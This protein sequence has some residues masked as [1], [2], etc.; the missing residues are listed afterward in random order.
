[1]QNYL[2]ADLSGFGYREIGLAAELL[3]ALSNAEYAPGLE[4]IIGAPGLTLEMN[5][6][7]GEVFLVDDDANVYML[8]DS[9][10]LERF[11]NCPECGHESFASEASEVS[12]D[13]VTV[14]VNCKKSI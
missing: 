14:C 10:R 8:N 4:P 6:Y 2:T 13:G 1:M 7:G 3:E 9:E 5:T 12:K 11:T